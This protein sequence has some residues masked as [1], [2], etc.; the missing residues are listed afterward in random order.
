MA[1]II[2]FFKAIILF[3]IFLVVTSVA[4]N[5]K[6]MNDWQCIGYCHPPRI[7]LCIDNICKCSLYSLPYSP[8]ERFDLPRDRVSN[9][10]VSGVYFQTREASGSIH[11]DEDLGFI[12]CK[13][14]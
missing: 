2:K 9:D 4:V 10:K 7:G 5:G 8:R 3:Y 1:Q 11:E 14:D 13:Q 6:C 12:S